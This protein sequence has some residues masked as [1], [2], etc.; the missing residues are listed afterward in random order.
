MKLYRDVQPRI[1][2]FLPGRSEILILQRQ[3]SMLYKNL[4][5]SYLSTLIPVKTISRW[6]ETKEIGTSSMS[7]LMSNAYGLFPSNN[8]TAW[9]GG[10]QLVL[11]V[12]AQNNNTI[13][14]VHSVGPLILEP[15]IEHPNVTAV[16]VVYAY[17]FGP[18]FIW[19][20]RSCGRVLAVKKPEMPLSMFSMA[21]GTR[22][23]DCRTQLPNGR[24]IIQLN[25]L[26]TEDRTRSCRFP[27]TKG[28]YDLSFH[29]Q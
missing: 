11:T 17:T 14:V 18:I 20:F 1:T 29:R 16:C 2:R 12:A 7:R 26:P 23:V 4:Q 8:L 13:V 9:N 19:Y 10:D 22:R 25:L 24:P 27:I 28:M 5:L 6:P 3:R 21:T 15:W